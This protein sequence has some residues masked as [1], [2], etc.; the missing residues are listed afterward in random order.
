MLVSAA[1]VRIIVGSIL[2]ACTHNIITVIHKKTKV[3]STSHIPS[4]DEYAN[5]TEDEIKAWSL[6]EFITAYQAAKATTAELQELQGR[7]FEAIGLLNG[8]HRYV[9]LAPLFADY[10]FG[11]GVWLGKGFDDSGLG[12]NVFKGQSEDGKLRSRRFRY[13]LQ[14]SF[15]GPGDAVGL[16]Y[17]DFN[18]DLLTNGMRDEV[19]KLNA[20]VYLGLGSYQLFGGMWNPAPFLVRVSDLPKKSFRVRPL[21]QAGREG[22]YIAHLRIGGY[23]GDT[24]ES[25]SATQ[26]HVDGKAPGREEL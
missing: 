9:P 2:V 7:E 21:E 13:K 11:P 19:R 15:F 10:M 22:W 1:T 14:P 26:T 25:E 4:A 8:A 17:S 3:G 18:G 12:Y 5:T 20:K 23:G 24:T 6:S 16:N